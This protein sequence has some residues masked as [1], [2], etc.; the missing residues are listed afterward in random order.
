MFYCNSLL[1]DFMRPQ[2]W[3]NDFFFGKIAEFDLVY[4]WPI[5]ITAWLCCLT[6]SGSDN[7]ENQAVADKKSSGEESSDNTNNNVDKKEPS[8]FFSTHPQD[9]KRINSF[10]ENAQK[11]GWS[12]TGKLTPLPD[13]FTFWKKL[14]LLTR[15]DVRQSITRD[16]RIRKEKLTNEVNTSVKTL[17]TIESGFYF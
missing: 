5:Q 2:N 14:N 16:L 7:E 6:C 9:E 11:N 13:F 17:W 12:E 4:C 10:S 15:T 3:E 8:D 1:W